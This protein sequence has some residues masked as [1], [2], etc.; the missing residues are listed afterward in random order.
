MASDAAGCGSTVFFVFFVHEVLLLLALIMWCRGT[1]QMPAG[2]RERERDLGADSGSR[3]QTDND[4]LDDDTRFLYDIVAREHERL[5][6]NIDAIDNALIAI[7]VGIVAAALFAGDKFAAFQPN[8]RCA[9]F[10]LLGEAVLATI[11]GYVSRTPDSGRLDGFLV[12]FATWPLVATLAAIEGLTLAS[13]VTRTIRRI[14]RNCAVF[15]TVLVVTAGILI[16]VGHAHG[17]RG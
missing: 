1:A 8:D 16:I 6:Q 10:L 13:G 5:V 7:A 2:G 9:A 17:V 11:A 4:E 14:K 15:A 3:A 12:D